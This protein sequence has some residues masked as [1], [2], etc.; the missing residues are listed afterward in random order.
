M[1]KARDHETE[2]DIRIL[3][4]WR[5]IVSFEGLN[6]HGKVLNPSLV[7]I[8]SVVG[9]LVVLA[10]QMEPVDAQVVRNSFH[11]FELVSVDH[12]LEQ[13]KMMEFCLEHQALS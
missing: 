10:H 7:M 11:H 8:E 1:R 9:K 5:G 13:C 2:R 4:A 3:Q 12:V 6:L